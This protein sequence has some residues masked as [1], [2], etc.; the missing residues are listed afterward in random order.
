MLRTWATLA[1]TVILGTLVVGI[2]H[3]GAIPLGQQISNGDF[4]NDATPSLTSWTTSGTANARP[5]TDALNASGGNAGFNTFFA[6]S[7]AALGDTAGDISGTPFAGTHSI[8]QT[9][10]LP[11]ISGTY[12][13]TI[14][15][16]TVFD[17]EGQNNQLDTF[18]A[19]LFNATSLFSQDLFSQNSFTLPTCGPLASCANIQLAQNAFSQTLVDLL[20]GTYTLKFE[21]VEQNGNASNTAAGID[22]VSVIANSSVPEPS[23]LLLLMGAAFVGV[24]L[25]A[26]RAR[27]KMSR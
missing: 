14:S 3:A 13:L 25:L 15:F 5:S 18:K 11:A 1:I 9:F 23:S 6:S 4:G 19:F 16:R 8:S 2:P 17:G 26:R 27:G 20:P 24:S 12:N 22:S 7:F 21:L 10:I